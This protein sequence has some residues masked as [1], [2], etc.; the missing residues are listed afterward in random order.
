MSEPD[1]LLHNTLQVSFSLR[2]VT[3]FNILYTWA[4]DRGVCACLYQESVHFQLKTE[5]K[6]VVAYGELSSSSK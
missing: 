4:T 3:V 1:K 6:Q 5:D 2:D